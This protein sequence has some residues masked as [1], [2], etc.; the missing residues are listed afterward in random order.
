MGL[1]AGSGV[2]KSMLLGMMTRFTNADVIVVGLIGERGREVHVF[3]AEARGR[4]PGSFHR[5]RRRG[6]TRASR[7][8]SLA[9]G[10]VEAAEE[11]GCV[12]I[13]CRH[14][15]RVDLYWPHDG[16]PWASLLAHRRATGGGFD[17]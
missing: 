17:R 15:P 6:F 11:A 14:L 8:R 13:G 5:V 3:A 16:S 7:E 2:G 1:F 9:H 4:P 10:L 12:T